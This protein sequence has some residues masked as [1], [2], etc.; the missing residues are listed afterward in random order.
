MPIGAT[1]QGTRLKTDPCFLPRKREEKEG[2]DMLQSFLLFVCWGGRGGG[3]FF[4]T[5]RPF[6]GGV[7]GRIATVRWFASMIA[8]SLAAKE[9][10]GGEKEAK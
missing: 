9:I 3:G 8:P 10:K 7:K 4:P 5:S 1:I 6:G 2:L